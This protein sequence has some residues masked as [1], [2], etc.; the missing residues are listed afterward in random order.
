MS[1]EVG[2]RGAHCVTRSGLVVLL[3]KLW[4]VVCERGDIPGKRGCRY[5][6]HDERAPQ[7]SGHQGREHEPRM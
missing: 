7:W 5:R 6:I 2:T 4:S 3:P 1:E